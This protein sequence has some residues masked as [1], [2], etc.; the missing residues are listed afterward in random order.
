[1][2][3]A[4]FTSD[5]Y[6]ILSDQEQQLLTGGADFKVS[7]SNFAQKQANLEGTTNAG[8]EGSDSNGTSDITA[9]N[10]AAT[11]LLGLGAASIP[12]FEPLGPAPVLNSTENGNGE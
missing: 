12:N 1:M 5:L 7:E 10:T 6:V 9:I 11:N 2:S 8:L 3:D 4:I